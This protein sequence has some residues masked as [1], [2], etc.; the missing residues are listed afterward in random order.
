MTTMECCGYK[1][2]HSEGYSPGSRSSAGLPSARLSL[3]SPG[4]AS[5]G[6][7][8]PAGLL[9]A[10][11]HRLCSP[12]SPASLFSRLPSFFLAQGSKA[13]L[14]K[15]VSVITVCCQ[16]GCQQAKHYLSKYYL[17]TCIQWETLRSGENP[18]HKIPILPTPA[19]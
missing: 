14:L 4:A 19:S 7:S 18:G 13:S 8:V 2:A 16:G 9:S 6:G 17:I 3:C 15:A 12:L 11:Q 10:P 5:T 1:G